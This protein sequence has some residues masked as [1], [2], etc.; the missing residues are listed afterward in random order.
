MLLAQ[1]GLN[2]P[3]LRQQINPEERQAYQEI[4]KARMFRSSIGANGN[5]SAW[6]FPSPL[7]FWTSLRAASAKAPPN[8]QPD[9]ATSGASV[10][11]A[12]TGREIKIASEKLVAGKI[13]QELRLVAGGRGL[14]VTPRVDRRIV[15][16][17]FVVHVRAGRASADTAVTNHLCRA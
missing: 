4:L 1:N 9:S 14:H 13:G 2:D 6:F 10:S 12:A 5:Q 16:S 17:H 3:K 8:I 15:H 7:N 11:N